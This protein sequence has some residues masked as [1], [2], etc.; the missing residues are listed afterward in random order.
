MTERKTRL[1]TTIAATTI[2]I[3]IGKRAFDVE[4]VGLDL[5]TPTENMVP[6]KADAGIVPET[7]S[8]AVNDVATEIQRFPFQYSTTHALVKLGLEIVITAETSEPKTP[9]LE[10]TLTS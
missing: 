1:T 5:G 8:G 6:V 4:L 10:E 7:V 3:A 2:E 9:L